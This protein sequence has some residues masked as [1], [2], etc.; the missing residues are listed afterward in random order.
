MERSAI[1]VSRT[2]HSGPGFRFAS[3]GLRLYSGDGRATAT[4]KRATT[5]MKKS[6][7]KEGKSAAASP[8]RP[9]D[10]RIKEL[11][12][13]RGET[14]A[15]GRVLIQQAHPPEGEEGKRR[16]GPGW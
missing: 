11:N 3:S 7:A 6:A 12:D 13:W 14:R 4:M 10:A 8:S 9:I 5:T 2:Q 16:R 15:P 1:R